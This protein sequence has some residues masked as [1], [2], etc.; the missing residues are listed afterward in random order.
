MGRIDRIE[1]QDFKSYAGH[2]V[3]G[4]FRGFT[5]V[6]GPNGSGLC[7]AWHARVSFETP[8]FLNAGKSNMMDAISFVL[9]LQA[10]HLRGNTLKDLV[11]RVEGASSG[12]ESASV[13][14]IYAVD[15][16]ELP[17][18]AAGSEIIFTRQI[19]PAGV[20]TY[21]LD[22]KEVAHA[23]YDA[24]LQ[25]IG[26]LTKARNFLVF[27]VCAANLNC[28]ACAGQLLLRRAMFNTW[29]TWIRH[30]C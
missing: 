13:S 22:G 7:C 2:Q 16:G 18:R 19:S 28:G 26:V 17:G 9:G 3:I 23:V 29:A 4:P 6:I 1:V 24:Q 5:A 30:A 27:Q 21:K 8:Y 12:P 20:S 11:F 10:R 14:L 25:D 15:A